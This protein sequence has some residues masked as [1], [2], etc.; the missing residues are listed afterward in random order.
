MCINVVNLTSKLNSV[1]DYWTPRIIGELN[2][3]HVKIAKF[4]GDF[5]MHK[6]DD[7]DELFL[8]IQGQL[9]I[10]LCDRT[11]ELNTGEL[12]VI[13]KGIEHRP[14]APKEVSVMLFEPA[15]TRNTGNVQNALTVTDLEKI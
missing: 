8:V 1:N 14:Y 3:Q 15:S 11:L 12:V 13:P 10:E 7:E 5:V 2:Q 6:H 4:K 9:F